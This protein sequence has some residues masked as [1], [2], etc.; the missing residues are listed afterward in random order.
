MAWS[1]LSEAQKLE[2]LYAQ[3]IHKD[4]QVEV[5]QISLNELAKKVRKLEKN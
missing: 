4:K 3:L 2:E 1:D 5:L